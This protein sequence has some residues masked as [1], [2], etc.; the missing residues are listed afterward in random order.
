MKLFRVYD[1]TNHRWI[2]DDVLI[3]SGG[4]AAIYKYRNDSLYER[5]VA[6]LDTYLPDE[7]EIEWGTGVY[8]KEDNQIYVGDIVEWDDVIGSVRY[9]T[10][11]SGFYLIGEE[12][13]VPLG[14]VEGEGTVTG[15]THSLEMED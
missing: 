1:K 13:K 14:I 11:H 2:T 8:D 9:D 12:R 15:N 4:G 5:T 6:V 3:D 7:V 10:Y